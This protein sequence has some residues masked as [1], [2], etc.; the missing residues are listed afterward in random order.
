MASTIKIKDLAKGERI[1]LTDGVAVVTSVRRERAMDVVEHVAGGGAYLINVKVVDG[2]D[3]G[4][5]F[6]DQLYHGNQ[7]VELAT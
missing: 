4:E 6:A 7:E 5:T 1:L 2:P 3:K